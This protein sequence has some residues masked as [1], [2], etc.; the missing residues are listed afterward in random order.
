MNSLQDKAV[1]MRI[2]YDDYNQQSNVC[3]INE[4]YNANRTCELRFTVPE[5]MEPPILIYY[6]LTNF[7]QNHRTYLKSFDPEQLYGMVGPRQPVYER[8]CQ[9]LNKLGNIALNPCGLI[10]NTFFND[11]FTLLQGK[12][13]LGQPLVMHEQGIAWQSDIDQMYNQPD[14]FRYEQCP[15]G[16]CDTSCCS[17]GNWSCTKPYVDPQGNCYRYFYPHDDTTQYLYETYPDI[18]SPL[19]GVTNEHFIVWMKVA[20]QPNF[21]KLYA[22]FDQPLAKGEQLV[23][24][25]NA[26]YVV[27]RFQGSKSLLIA[28]TNVFG[29]KNPY[30]GS[31][32]IG[33]GGFILAMGV[34]FGLKQLFK[35]RKLADPKYLHYK[36]D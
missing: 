7:H 20:M 11:Y 36:E 22:W 24:Q 31:S 29:G 8:F 15:T 19:E 2:T 21:R 17:G 6:E 33:A 26:N 18:I 23:F 5:H 27:S 10:A 12:S 16:Q 13:A 35:P 30:L 28:K 9:P 1:E 25:V 32:F 3:G 34:L 4:T 14:G